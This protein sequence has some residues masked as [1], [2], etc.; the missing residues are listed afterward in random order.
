MTYK[1]IQERLGHSTLQMTM[2]LYS[3]LEP[4]KKNKELEL[5]TK[6]ANF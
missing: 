5:F 4:E 2:D 6:Y 3:H 1:V